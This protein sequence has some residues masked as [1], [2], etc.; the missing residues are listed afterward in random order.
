MA[1]FVEKHF[2][3]SFSLLDRNCEKF[4]RTLRL[5]FKIR[6]KFRILHFHLSTKISNNINIHQLILFNTPLI[7]VFRAFQLKM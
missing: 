2:E 5:S 4:P 6:L 1:S 7:L 3:Q